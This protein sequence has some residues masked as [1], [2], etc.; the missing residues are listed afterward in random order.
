MSDDKI[1]IRP[2][3]DLPARALVLQPDVKEQRRGAPAPVEDDP[4]AVRSTRARLDEGVALT[5]A[6][7]LDVAEGLVVPVARMRPSTLLGSGKVD[8]I[9]AKLEAAPVDLVV[10]NRPL[11]PIQQRNLEKAWNVKVIDRIWLILEIFADRARTREGR[12]QVELARLGYQRSRLVRSWTHLE[13]QRG[14]R[15]FLA[16]PGETQ[17]ETDR[18]IIDDKMAKLKLQLAEVVRTRELHRKKRREVPYPVVALVGYTNAGKS[19]LFNRVTGA[20]VMAKDMLFATLDPTMRALDLPSGRRVILSDTVGFVSE[21]PTGL[22]A[23]FRATLE[24]VREAALIIHV[25]DIADPDT[26]AQRRD[27]LHVLGELG[28]GHRLA[29]D[30]L[31]FRNKLDMLEGEARERVLNEAA[32]AED[33]VA[34]SALSGEG[35]DRLFAAIDARLA[36]GD[37]LAHFD[38]PHADGQAL[39]WLYEHGEV[40]ERADDE[41]VAHVAVRLKPQDLSRFHARWPH[42]SAPVSPT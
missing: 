7:G 41:A 11:T 12:L 35:L 33:A 3:G 27:V 26:G 4:E 39:A 40:A 6:L 15:G 16:G 25:R 17:I 13:R 31:E 5:G 10:M 32:R 14:G 37:E 28:M 38:V 30:V 21:L 22:I 36:I 9:K 23:A 20:S 2:D 8:E 24:E 1:I 19:T 18:R 29:D 34:G 42:L